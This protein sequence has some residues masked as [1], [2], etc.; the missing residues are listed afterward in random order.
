MKKWCMHRAC[1]TCQPLRYVPGLG[2]PPAAA[3]IVG[4]PIRL[5]QPGKIRFQSLFKTSK[6]TNTR[7][8]PANLLR[9]N[10]LTELLRPK[11]SVDQD[12]SH[13]R[14]GKCKPG[15]SVSR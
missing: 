6:S 1:A 7:G 4:F 2:A 10:W 14:A 5:Q 13:L 3:G 8:V 15:V 12:A 11:G 9:Q